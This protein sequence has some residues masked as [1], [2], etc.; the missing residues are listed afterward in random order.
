MWID[1]RAPPGPL[2][3]RNIEQINKS[4]FKEKGNKKEEKKNFSGIKGSHIAKRTLGAFPPPPQ[5][6]FRSSLTMLVRKSI[7]DPVR[8]WSASSTTECKSTWLAVWFLH[9]AE[10]LTSAKAIK[11]LNGIAKIFEYCRGDI[12]DGLGHLWERIWVL[13]E[14]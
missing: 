2:N 6:F 14:G 13:K 8:S 10:P 5:N 4:P 3:A 1:S 12:S 9:V 11:F 7:L